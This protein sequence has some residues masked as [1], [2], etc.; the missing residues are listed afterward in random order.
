MATCFSNAKLRRMI[1]PMSNGFA[2]V[3]EDDEEHGERFRDSRSKC[4]ER[5]NSAGMGEDFVGSIS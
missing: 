1:E 5:E 3:L 2:A 4:S